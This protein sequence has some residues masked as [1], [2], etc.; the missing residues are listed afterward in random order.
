MAPITIQ[1]RGSML[2]CPGT[3]TFIPQ[4]LAIR[5]SGRTMTLIE[6]STRRMSL[7]RWEITDSLVSS[8][9]SATS[10]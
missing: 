6:V 5:V 10:L 8:S 9:A 4:M 1:K 7:T 2:S 3:R